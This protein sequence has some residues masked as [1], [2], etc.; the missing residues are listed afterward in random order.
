MQSL[1]SII[2]FLL[3]GSTVFGQIPA[4]VNEEQIVEVPRNVI[5]AVVAQQPDSPISFENVK[6]L[7]RVGGGTF[8]SYQLRNTGKKKIVG[9]K[10]GT[11]WGHEYEAPKDIGKIFAPGSL[12]T[13]NVDL[14]KHV[15]ESSTRLKR[16]LGLTPP[17]R[18]LVV[19]M[20]IRV[21]FS[22]GTF[23]SDEDSYN[24]LRAFA[25]RMDDAMEKSGKEKSLR[26]KET[27]R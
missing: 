18:G 24:E 11:S 14:G 5:L 20:V 6:V 7:R 25:D 13:D 3:F 10:V 27:R 12:L 15:F 17:M 4:G 8:T 1:K 9:F 26:T 16:D 2:I 22:D 23:F 19:L 21:D